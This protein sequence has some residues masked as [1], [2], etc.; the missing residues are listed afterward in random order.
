MH[1]R[2][3]T[4]ERMVEGRLT[5]VAFQVIGTASKE[6]YISGEWKWTLQ[7]CKLCASFYTPGVSSAADFEISVFGGAGRRVHRA[8][9]RSAA[10]FCSR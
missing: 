6:E 9:R 7:S 5:M 8:P 1:F 2:G 4:R 3:A 10:E